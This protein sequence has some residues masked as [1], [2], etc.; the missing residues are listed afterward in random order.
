MIDPLHIRDSIF[1]FDGVIADTNKYKKKALEAG[2][3]HASPKANKKNLE[4]FL[5]YHSK[6]P[7][8][9][10]RKLINDWHKSMYGY[11]NERLNIIVQKFRTKF[12]SICLKNITHAK[13]IS[14]VEYLMENLK[15]SGKKIFIVT[16]GDIEYPINFLV[17][18]KKAYLV[19]GIIGGEGTKYQK[20]V[21]LLKNLKNPIFYGDTWGDY[22]TASKLKLSF[23]GITG[24]SQCT[25]MVTPKRKGNFERYNNFNF[26]VIKK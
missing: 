21:S 19:D 7:T 24:Y 15:L 17:S 3:L 5:N 25:K 10:A 12:R 2:F 22:L 1:D 6:N 16:A 13:W 9:N 14:G 20:T 18:Y 23:I 11:D 8:L 4:L 26:T